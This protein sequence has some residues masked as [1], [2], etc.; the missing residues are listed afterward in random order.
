VAG[1]LFLTIV[2]LSLVAYLV[3]RATAGRF[4]PDGG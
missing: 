1:Y 3:G 4:V 2:V